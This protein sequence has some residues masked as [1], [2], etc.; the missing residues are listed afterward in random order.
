[1]T[2]ETKVN[3]TPESFGQ[4]LERDRLEA[5]V[6][7]HVPLPIHVGTTVVGVTPEQKTK[8]DADA[9]GEA[10]STEAEF[11]QA[12]NEGLRVQY[13]GN[14]IPVSELPEGA[15]PDNI[16]DLGVSVVTGKPVTLE[17]LLRAPRDPDVKVLKAQVVAAF[18]HMGVDTK[19]FFGV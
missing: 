7:Y 5:K 10:V 3:R 19:K 17:Q 11:A 18:K 2:N 16:E 9:M 15:V 14:A 8:I 4:K 1:M 6:E 13:A 12:E